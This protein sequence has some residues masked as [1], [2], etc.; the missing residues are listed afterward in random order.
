MII[1]FI[2]NILYA[3]FKYI[4]VFFFIL[5]IYILRTP[6]KY[7]KYFSVVQNDHA[8]TEKKTNNILSNR[9]YDIPNVYYLQTY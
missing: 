5:R 3:I 2:L 7:F 8:C 4:S 1:N 6:I 9:N